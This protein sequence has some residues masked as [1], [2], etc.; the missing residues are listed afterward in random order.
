MERSEQHSYLRAK[1]VSVGA[2]V[3]ELTAI[4]GSCDHIA[5]LPAQPDLLFLSTYAHKG[6]RLNI[7]SPR[8]LFNADNNHIAQIVS[9]DLLVFEPDFLTNI[10]SIAKC[11]DYGTSLTY[12][13]DIFSP[14]ADDSPYI[15][16]GNLVGQIF[17]DTLYN[18]SSPLS[19][20]ESALRFMRKNVLKTAVCTDVK[21]VHRMAASERDNIIG[22]FAYLS[23]QDKAFAA[24]KALL[25]P[26]F[27]SEMLGLHGRMDLLEE[28]FSLLIELKAGK[29]DD[30]RHAHLLPHFVQI[31]LYL[32]IIRY[33][34]QQ[35]N[36][37][38][39]LMYAQYA[40]GLHPE[41]LNMDV[42][43]QAMCF[44]NEIVARN[45][46]YADA[47]PQKF[48]E[49]LCEADF[50][51][52]KTFSDKFWSLYKWP[53]ISPLLKTIKEADEI[54]KAYFYRFFQFLQKE[55]LLGVRGGAHKEI[56]G[57]SS[58]WNT[59][60]SEKLDYGSILPNLHIYELLLNDEGAVFAVRCTVD[61]SDKKDYLSCSNFRLNDSVVF[62]A[63][64]PLKAPDVRRA[65]ILRG[66]LV[67][68]SESCITVE[69]L[70][71]QK[72]K[73]FF[74]QKTWCVEHDLSVVSRGL[75]RGLF[76]FLTLSPE[77]RAFFL[78]EKPS[79]VD[80]KVALEGDYG[81][82]NPLVLSA[83]QTSPFFEIIGP[84]GTGKT[85]HALLNIV[86]EELLNAEN[87]V[88]LAAYTHRAVDEICDKLTQ[89][90]IQYIRL[91]HYHS[92][93]KP[94]AKNNFQTF[95]E[96]CDNVSQVKQY[97]EQS[98]VV[99]ATIAHLSLH[100]EIFALCRFNLAVIDEASQLL[101]PHLLPLICARHGKREAIDRFVFIGDHKQL[102]AIVRQ[103]ERES[104]V[105]DPMLNALGICNCRTSLFERL[106]Q[107][108]PS[109]L[110]NKQGRMHTDLAAFSNIQFYD[111]VITEVPLPHQH[112]S[113]L[114]QHARN[115]IE[116]FLA[117][118]RT[119]FFDIVPQ[120]RNFSSK[121][122]FKE[123][124]TIAQIFISM[125]RLY[126]RNGIEISEGRT[127]GCIV[128]YRN[129]ISL[130]RAAI[131]EKEL[132]AGFDS[133]T[134]VTIDTVER[135]QGSQRD[136][137]VYGF[138]VHS[139]YQ[140]T[141]LSAN[142]FREA[143]GKIIDR[144]LNVALTRAREQLFVVGNARLL[145]KDEIFSQLINA[146]PHFCQ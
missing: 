12:Y 119:V 79:V 109:F 121:T 17:D 45:L 106:L 137:I 72:N 28:D 51:Q 91:G 82:F 9:Y 22:Q 6:T 71:S 97:V 3:V 47:S 40:D 92:T 127:F 67:E 103:S 81:E 1:V 2:E 35:D 36:T 42:L 16:L 64:N 99:V 11:F 32:A 26:T 68:L 116:A 108:H 55:D 104:A 57:L 134:P 133:P 14:P 27:Y 62:Y 132:E 101:E 90:Q 110:M 77:R 46:L 125:R 126:E 105:N 84:P 129:Q 20:H 41:Q 143:S 95:V 112:K 63:Y 131:R 144:K 107:C 43:R 111:G 23:S 138:T 69:F 98:R 93:L 94:N 140:L 115:P 8:I 118:H 145:S 117:T 25:E 96:Q 54:S 50:R 34:F 85:S 139:A 59:P 123:A 48:F 142:N 65:I 4:D 130:I 49:E 135:F 89:A 88:L 128:P 87:R 73:G 83:K 37:A 100:Q 44:R 70:N 52:N 21:M 18:Q 78:G 80:N 39:Y 86:K 75:Y 141:F 33:N 56:D 136:V 113:L 24:E 38:A 124:E 53:A 120:R 31:V 7:I 76:N 61:E 122:N 29:R 13:F 66:Q 30:Y 102:P 10:T 19:Y 146:F 58:Y 114:L 74:E 5:L 60:Y 15:L